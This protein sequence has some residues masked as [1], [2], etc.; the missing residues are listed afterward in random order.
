MALPIS[1]STVTIHT[2]FAFDQEITWTAA[3]P[4]PQILVKNQMISNVLTEPSVNADVVNP[5]LIRDIGRVNVT[6]IIYD[7]TNNAV[8][9][10][11]TYIDSLPRNSSKPVVFTWP[12]PFKWSKSR[13]ANNRPTLCLALTVP[14]VWLI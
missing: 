6:A 7:T 12:G 13:L 3:T 9:A 8:A 4:A 1:T 14:A 10:S 11:K 2:T 5:S